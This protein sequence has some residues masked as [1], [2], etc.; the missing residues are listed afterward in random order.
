[1]AASQ[2]HLYIHIVWATFDRLPLVTPALEEHLY[3]A[4]TRECENLK[5]QMIA[6]GGIADHVHALVRLHSQVAVAAIVQ[7]M[8]GSSS[9]W[10]HERDNNMMAFAWQDGYGAF[11]V[12]LSQI[13]DTIRYIE[14]QREHH[15]TK[16]FQEEY[17]HYVHFLKKYDV[18]FDERYVWG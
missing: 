10:I 16:S 12:G 13:D 4:I 15:R 17:V 2:T 11:S 5:C 1:M 8:K 7:Q 9:R 14:G 3:A 18:E 6:I